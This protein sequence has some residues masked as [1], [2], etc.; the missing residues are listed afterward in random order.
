MN[1][2]A[3][4]AIGIGL[5]TGYTMFVITGVFGAGLSTAIGLGLGSFFWLRG[6]KR[7][8]PR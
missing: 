1:R 2:E 7:N 4:V 5:T 3:I 6:R 8:P